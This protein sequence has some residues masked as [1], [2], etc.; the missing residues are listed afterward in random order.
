MITT[1]EIES[2]LLTLTFKSYVFFSIALSCLISFLIGL[3]YNLLIVNSQAIT[4][5]DVSKMETWSIILLSL[6]IAPLFETVIFQTLLLGF[7]HR[8]LP[9]YSNLIVSLLFAVNHFSSIKQ[10][11]ATFFICLIFNYSYLH[12][13]EREWN[14][15]LTVLLIHSGY[16]LF[17]STIFLSSKAL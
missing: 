6:I 1:E 12:A 9:K 4:E 16:N 3:I 14:P 7:T 11:V 2:K 15:F 10:I 13:K 17:V 8:Y 5:S